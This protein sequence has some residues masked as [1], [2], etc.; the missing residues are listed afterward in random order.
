MSY[1][2]RPGL[3]S[4]SYTSQIESMIPTYCPSCPPSLVLSLVQAESSG[5]QYGSSGAVLTSSA[6]AEGLFQLEPATAASLGVDPTSP[7]GNIQ[8][9]LTYL[10]QLY[11]EYGNWTDALEAYNEGPG[12]LAANQAAG[13][14]P[15]SAGY[16]SSILASAGISDDSEDDSGD[17]PLDALNSATEYL[18]GVSLAGLSGLAWA[19]IAAGLI[20]LLIVFRPG[21]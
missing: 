3:G 7:T 15:V 20:A 17:S 1:H 14:T 10:Q 2:R 18:E 8:G 19:G 16:A 6:G 12:N 13:I 21:K 9:G 11:D 5:N 4:T